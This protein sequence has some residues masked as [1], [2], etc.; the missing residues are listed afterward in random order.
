MFNM[1]KI[2]IIISKDNINNKYNLTLFRSPSPSTLPMP[3]SHW[4]KNLK[5]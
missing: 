4:L 3:P 1:Q 2:S 5:T